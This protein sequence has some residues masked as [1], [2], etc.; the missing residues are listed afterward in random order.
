MKFFPSLREF[1]AEQGTA[2]SAPQGQRLLLV[3]SLEE[4]C[5]LSGMGMYPAME[6]HGGFDL[7]VVDCDEFEEYEEQFLAPRFDHGHGPGIPETA[8]GEFEPTRHDGPEGPRGQTSFSPP[9][10]QDSLQAP[11][12]F[13]RITLTQIIVIVTRPPVSAELAPR[14]A[15]SGEEHPAP[16]PLSSFNP[17]TI[18]RETNTIGNARITAT[19]AT[20][21]DLTVA[22]SRAS[23][24]TIVAAASETSGL[25]SR[26]E[27]SARDETVA[28]KLP[29]EK[30]LAVPPKINQ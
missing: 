24:P 10:R 5:V 7:G 25:Q 29:T 27:G 15:F 17:T 6:S 4:R 18:L 13:E 11:G 22:K 28:Q 30:V 14:P 1:L 16:G 26:E 19:I 9:P 23:D 21:G 20:T 8:E 12:E 3:E 2:K